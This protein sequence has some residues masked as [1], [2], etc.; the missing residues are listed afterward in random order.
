MC[1]VG[2]KGLNRSLLPNP[3]KQLRPGGKFAMETQEVSEIRA[4]REAF[5]VIF[6]VEVVLFPPKRLRLH[7]ASLCRG[8]GYG[9]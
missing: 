6:K 8:T 3:P 4:T 7:N 1:R 5:L 2:T 9:D